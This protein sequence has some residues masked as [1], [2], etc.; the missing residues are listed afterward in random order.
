M[1]AT[2][3]AKRSFENTKMLIVDPKTITKI[4]HGTVA[5]LLKFFNPGDL[6]IVNVASTLPASFKGKIKR[7]A[8]DIEFRLAAFTGPS[9]SDLRR[10]SA[11]SFGAGNWRSSTESRGAPPKLVENDVVEIS[12]ALQLK[13]KKVD[14]RSTRLLEI[15][16]ISSNLLHELY[17]EGKPIQYSYLEQDLAIW[18]QQTIFHGPPV[19]VEP[20]SAAFPL[21]WD[22]LLKLKNKGVSI[23]PIIHSA[24]I[25]SSGNSEL[26]ALLPLSE[27][28]EVPN[29][30]LL[31]VQSTQR[32]GRRVAAVGN[33]VTRAI[34][35]AIATGNTTGLTSL[36]LGPLSQLHG[37]DVLITGMH[38]EGSSHAELMHAFCD[39][40]TL[41]LAED[42]AN[43]KEYRSHEYGDLMLLNC[44]R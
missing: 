38:E 3:N 4:D 33:S 1:R 25:S 5:D 10:W 9:T 44:G 35:S 20:P 34:E 30:T 42:E 19:A 39:H 15:E 18:D 23:A 6:L 8:E 43:R 29:E 40:E 2:A 22:L 31:K 11:I 27:Y 13:I 17:Q 12:D 7:T 28:Y 37:I 21:T 32:N 36:K 41:K 24:G 26:D 16:W 14:L